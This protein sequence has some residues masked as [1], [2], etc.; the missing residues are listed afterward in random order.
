METIIE[1]CQSIARNRVFSF[2][3]SVVVFAVSLML[4]VFIISL[5]NVNA[6]IDKVGEQVV[7]EAYLKQGTSPEKGKFLAKAAGTIQGVESSRFVP[8]SEAVERLGGN[9]G[10][11]NLLIDMDVLG[12]IPSS[13]EVNVDDAKYLPE[14]AGAIAD[15]DGVENVRY[16][17]DAAAKALMIASSVKKICLVLFVLLVIS[18]IAV[19]SAV[20]ALSVASERGNIEVLRLIGANDNFIMR[21]YI[22]EGMIIGGIGAI[23]SIIALRI[24]YDSVVTS[25]ISILAPLPA[26]PS[27]YIASAFMLIFGMGF[28][29]IGSWAAAKHFLSEER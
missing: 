26:F 22:Y 8:S 28:G 24:G 27:L 12:F 13:I 11:A 4:G 2:I 7:I 10:T 23:A 16:G 15:Y 29:G 17:D 19:I 9:D 18:T 21:P 20:S 14:V 25:D 5:L 1:A 3:A 6:F